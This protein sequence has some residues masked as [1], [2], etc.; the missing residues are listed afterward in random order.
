MELDA[1]RSRRAL[2]LLA[3]A[4]GLRTPE[5]AAEGVVSVVEGTMERAIRVITVERGQDPR[6]CA[7]LAFGGAA[8]LHACG[9]ADALDIPTII[10]PTDPGLFSAWGVLEGEVVRDRRQAFHAF[11]P[12]YATLDT[13]SRAL[14]AA[15]R[16]DVVREGIP[17][18][19]VLVERW[20]AV[21][22]RGQSIE[23]EVKLDRGF[24]RAFDRAHQRRFHGCDPTRSIE[25][26]GIRATAFGAVAMP[27]R[28][29]SRTAYTRASRTSV[30]VWLAGRFRSASMHRREEL[31]RGCRIDGPAII[32]EYSSTTLVNAGWLAKVDGHGN[33]VLRMRPR[34]ESEHA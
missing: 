26:T 30:T 23:L 17:A 3:R 22:Y 32:T 10:V 8:G 31:D 9:L 15:V 34:P 29:P 11:D 16:R 24:R 20:I 14:A 1:E 18:R 4:M 13:K 21:R 5:Q 12:G 2:S 27:A 25:V 19:D 33:V 28:P 6:T 7:L